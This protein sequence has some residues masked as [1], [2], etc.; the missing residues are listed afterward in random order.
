MA[1]ANIDLRRYRDVGGEQDWRG[2][3]W[4]GGRLRVVKDWE[5]EKAR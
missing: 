2:A 5:R 3:G 1:H 4:K